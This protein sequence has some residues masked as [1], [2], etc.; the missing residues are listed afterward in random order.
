[1]WENIWYKN[2]GINLQGAPRADARERSGG[3]KAL[4]PSGMVKADW[5]EADWLEE[6]D[7]LDEVNWLDAVDIIDPDDPLKVVRRLL[8]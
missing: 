8:N 3:R 4:P 1:M 2:G 6:T 7:W 5:D